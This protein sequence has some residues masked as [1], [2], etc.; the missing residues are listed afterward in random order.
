MKKLRLVDDWKWVV[1]KTWSIRFTVLA[2]ICGGI[3]MLLQLFANQ[4][5]STAF[6]IA[7]FVFSVATG[8]S[9]V[10]SQDRD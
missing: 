8:I 2:S 10:F 3:N 1:K 5:S 4:N 6:L 9:R 7:A